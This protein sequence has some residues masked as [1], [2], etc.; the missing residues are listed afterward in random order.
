MCFYLLLLFSLSAIS[1]FFGASW[2][3]AHEAQM[4]FPRQEFWRRLHFLFQWMCVSI[5]N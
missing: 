1:D 5:L 4:G 3:T 2:T